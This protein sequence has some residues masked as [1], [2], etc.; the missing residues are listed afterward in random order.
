MPKKNIKKHLEKRGLST[1]GSHDVLTKRLI[2]AIDEDH[3]A[4]REQTFAERAAWEAEQEQL[5]EE[6]AEREAALAHLGK[7]NKK[8]T[9]LK[10]P[11]LRKQLEKRGLS[12]KGKKTA[13][14]ERLADAL[15][16]EMEGKLEQQKRIKAGRL[17]SP[18]SL[19]SRRQPTAIIRRSSGKSKR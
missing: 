4:H 13:L 7:L 3:A 8:F 2:K 18:R 1:K 9:K 11:G 5:A 17:G 14:L 6:Q 19:R 12:T 10:A 16:K 15:E